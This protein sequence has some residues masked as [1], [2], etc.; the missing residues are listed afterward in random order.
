MLL[1]THSQLQTRPS[2]IL[3]ASQNRSNQQTC[4]NNTLSNKPV[5][6]TKVSFSNL[7]L[8]RLGVSPFKVFNEGYIHKLNQALNTIDFEN[9][10][11]VMKVLAAQQGKAKK[12]YVLGNGGS[13]AVASHFAHNLSWDVSVKLPVEKKISALP[14]AQ[15][16]TDMTA[17]MNDVNGEFSF[18]TLVRD[19]MTPHDILVGIS[20]SGESQNLVHA[21]KQAEKLGIKTVGLVKEGSTLAKQ[22]TH[23]ITINSEDQQVI[24]DAQQAATHMMVRM[25]KSHLH[26]ENPALLLQED[27]A[28]L[29]TKQKNILSLRQE[30][31]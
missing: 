11:E 2:V 6:T 21:F 3:S 29:R 9:F 20:A 24:E 5:Q 12:I 18:A 14:L 22:A 10:H 19:H 1:G 28:T 13:E 15:L 17:R 16:S 4:L 31:K 23:A 30:L 25:L 8:V 7:N 26:Q 27:L